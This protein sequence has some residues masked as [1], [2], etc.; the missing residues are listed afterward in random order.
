VRALLEKL[1]I[2]PINPGA[3]NGPDGWIRDPQGKELI[4]FNPTTGQP[5]ARV[6]QCSAEGYQ[7]V[8][9]RAQEAFL[10]WRETPAPARG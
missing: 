9:E 6:L 3:C 7:R 5:I 4:S 1:H 10:E 2:D 8:V